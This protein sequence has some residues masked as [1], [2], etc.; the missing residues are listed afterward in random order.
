MYEVLQDSPDGRFGL[1]TQLLEVEGEEADA[2][3]QKFLN[4]LKHY[5]KEKLR[6]QRWGE[7]LFAKYCAYPE[8]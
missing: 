4:E 3:A 1:N 5:R 8:A 7:E 2:N 6:I